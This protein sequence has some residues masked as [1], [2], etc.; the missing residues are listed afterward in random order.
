VK[1]EE[2]EE[3]GKV[4]GSRRWR[5]GGAIELEGEGGVGIRKGTQGF[6]KEE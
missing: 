6:E 2:E 1:K 5:R 4:E 3:Q